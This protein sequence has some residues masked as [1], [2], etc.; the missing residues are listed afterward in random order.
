MTITNFDA[1]LD[2][3]AHLIVKTGVNVQP[4]QTIILYANIENASLA[5]KIT[6]EAYKFGATE[7]I[8]KWQDIAIAKAFL[9]NTTEERLVTIPNYL[10]V[11]AEELM[12]KHATRISL[13]SEDPDAFGD[14]DQTRLA[15]N[16]A[17]TGKALQVIRKA[18]MNNDISWLVVAAAGKKWAEKVFPKLNSDEAVEQLW[19][20]IFKIVH[21]NENND[22]VATWEQHIK[23]LKQKAIWLNSLNFKELKYHSAVTDLTVGLATNHIWEAADSLDRQG[24]LFV[25]NMPTEEVFTAPDYRNIHGTVT[26]TKPL[27]YSGVLIDGIK[28]T[29]ANGKVIKASAKHGEAA[30]LKLLDIDD[31]AKSLGEVSLVPFHSP[32]SQS[33]IIFYNTLIDENAS[34]HLALGAA[35]PFNVKDGTNLNSAELEALG[36]NQSQTHV[37]FMIGS[38]DMDIDGITYDNQIIPVFR[39]G[40]WA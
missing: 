12:G 35:Y 33:G 19:E 40:D 9:Q 1:K 26:S 28:L 15:N 25:A 8:V 38:S 37:D 18:T 5:R 3:Y 10:T 6:N 36:Q 29:F 21:I 7:V 30:L 13:I 32:I 23:L 24:N 20:Q 34:D 16:T 17:A 2:K 39:N 4:G 31:G 27:S 22:P 11:E 14:V